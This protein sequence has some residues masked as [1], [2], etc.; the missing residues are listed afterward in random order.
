MGKNGGE[1]QINKTFFRPG[2]K[3]Q[4]SLVSRVGSEGWLPCD[5][6]WEAVGHIK[7]LNSHSVE[8]FIFPEAAGSQGFSGESGA[9]AHIF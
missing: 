2:S 7:T 3:C 4:T 1:L 8:P 9:T 5:L 6:G